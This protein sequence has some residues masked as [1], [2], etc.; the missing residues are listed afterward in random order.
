LNRSGTLKRRVM[1]IIV[2][3]FAFNGMSAS[4]LAETPPASTPRPEPP[5]L[6]ARV[7]SVSE[8]ERRAYEVAAAVMNARSLLQRI[9]AMREYTAA[10]LAVL[11]RRQSAVRKELDQLMALI[12]E[13]KHTIA[14]R[15]DRVGRL[16]QA[17]YRSSRQSPLELLLSGGSLVDALARAEAF[18]GLMEQERHLRNVLHS[19]TIDL[20]WKEEHQRA[21]AADLR[22]LEATVAAKRDTLDL[23]AR[24][25]R[26]LVEAGARGGSAARLQAE[27]AIVRE[28]IADAE[29]SSAAAE[30][31]VARLAVGS[32]IELRRPSAWTWPVRGGTVSQEFGPTSFPLEPARFVNG[33]LF[34]HFHDGIDVA[35]PLY[36]VVRAAAEGQVAFVG[37]L[38]DGA[39]VIVIDHGD[40][41][42]SLYG[43]LDDAVRPPLVRV[44]DEVRTGDPIATIGLTGLT[45]GPH[46]HF[47]IRREGSPVDPRSMF[48]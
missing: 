25:S 23:L 35:A 19:L 6:E 27:A 24:R 28:L 44:G 38:R 16:L 47:A 45:T 43:H 31:I 18:L 2:I 22:Q 13:T 9:D 46:L 20:A 29:R 10:E 21:I 33:V 15:T 7:G 14:E 36:T 41:T 17:A 1:A 8:D 42:I 5:T 4:G 39:M 26:V 11:E 30:E 12:E 40:A 34:P 48:P 37:H 3:A 32:G